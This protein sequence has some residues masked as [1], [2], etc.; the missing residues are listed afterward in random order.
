MKAPKRP[1]AMMTLAQAICALGGM[2]LMLTALFMYPTTGCRVVAACFLYVCVEA[3]LLCGRTKKTTSF[4][5][6]NVKSLGRIALALCIAG[7]LL[8]WYGQFV[9]D[10]LL[11]GLPHVSPVIRVGLPS[12]AV[13]TIA[14]MIR[15][16][17]VLMRRALTMQEENELTV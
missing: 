2:L 12:F 5:D 14:L 16:V 1:V 8:L 9:M 3:F 13:L 17:Q 11:A 4:S 6:A 7:L 10:A 15:A